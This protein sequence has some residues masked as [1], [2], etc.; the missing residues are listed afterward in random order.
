MEDKKI[1]EV[2]KEPVLDNVVVELLHVVVFEHV[3][4]LIVKRIFS[5]LDH[6]ID[7]GF[8]SF[9]LDSFICDPRPFFS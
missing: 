1:W 6:S 7:H 8:E 9:I 3:A 4:C 5:G 2:G